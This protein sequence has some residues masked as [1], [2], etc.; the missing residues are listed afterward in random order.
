MTI[1]IPDFNKK[2]KIVIPDF[3]K[4]IKEIE[5]PKNSLE[6]DFPGMTTSEIIETG[7]KG[8]T[9]EEKKRTL[10]YLI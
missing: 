6:R 9:E 2:K 7:G 10:L 5:V 1:Q 4:E 8:Y 3:E